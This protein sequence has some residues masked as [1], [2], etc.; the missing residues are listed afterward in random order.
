MI[1]TI[2]QIILSLFLI[3]IMAFI[4]YSIYN[5]E[6]LDNINMSLISTNK[7]KTIVFSGR[8]NYNNNT[9]I[10][11]E[12][13]DKN[14]YGY[15][16][17]NASINQNGGAEYSYNFWLYFDPEDTSKLLTTTNFGGTKLENV[18][19]NA[20]DNYTQAADK[21]NMAKYL[22]Y[23]ILFYKGEN[24]SPFKINTR[25][26]EC[27]VNNYDPR[28]LIKAPLIK[29]RNDCKEIIIENNNINFP[30]TYNYHKNLFAT[31]NTDDDIQTRYKNKFG[32][33]NI[34]VEKYKNKFNMIT[35]VMQEQPKKEDIFNSAKSNCRTYFNGNLIDD[36]LTSTDTYTLK[37]MA[38]TDFESSVIK[39]NLS[40]LRIFPQTN[41]YKTPPVISDKTLPDK[42]TK[43][44]KLQMADL[45]YYNYAITQT[46]ITKLYNDGFNNFDANIVKKQNETK[47]IKG[48]YNSQIAPVSGVAA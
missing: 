7:K 10:N 42:I 33:K 43:S 2:I 14:L 9:D 31:C 44:P 28:I 11:I 26:L 41:I 6:Y 16:D 23:I 22:Q 34:N 25:D 36:T 37:N 15:K 29:I 4:G 5:H 32:I 8:L 3:S 47:Y 40:K 27:D 48:D 35:V 24:P 46:E 19:P 38:N 30:E 18:D 13:Y 20:L 17:I 1:N 45:T 21:N 39:N 12:T